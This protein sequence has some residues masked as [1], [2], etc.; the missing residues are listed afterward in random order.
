MEN[1]ITFRYVGSKICKKVQKLEIFNSENQK[2]SGSGSNFRLRKFYDSSHKHYQTASI[3]SS[4][5]SSGKVSCGLNIAEPLYSDHP[6]D[7]WE[8]HFQCSL[9]RGL[10][11]AKVE[12]F[13]LPELEKRHSFVL[14]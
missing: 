12:Q 8:L 2:I 1:Q 4:R 5:I 14:V 6:R 11:K 10:V 7:N 3:S 13:R 9:S